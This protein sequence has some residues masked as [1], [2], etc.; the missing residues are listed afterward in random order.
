MVIRGKKQKD[1][2]SPI[3][4]VNA[5]NAP[6]TGPSVSITL[7]WRWHDIDSDGAAARRW[8]G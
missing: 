3:P 6:L 5:R 8:P 1:M 7:W 2:M 4:I